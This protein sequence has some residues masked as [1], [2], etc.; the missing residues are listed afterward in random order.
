MDMAYAL[1]P[2]GYLDLSACETG[3]DKRD[4][5]WDCFSQNLALR[6][7]VARDGTRVKGFTPTSFAHI[8]YGTSKRHRSKVR[9]KDPFIERRARFLPMV[10]DALTGTQKTLVWRDRK[11]PMRRIL[12]T[13]VAPGSYLIVVLDEMEDLYWFRSAYP[14]NSHY[15]EACVKGRGILID[16]WD[17]AQPPATAMPLKRR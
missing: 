15:F 12:S 4:A 8:A 7:I 16:V 3:S 9:P 10:A 17:T 13:E 5:A 14:A 11:R 1:T 6:P 2:A